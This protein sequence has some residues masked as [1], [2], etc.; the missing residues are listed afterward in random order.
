LREISDDWLICLYREGNQVAIDLLFERYSVFL[1]GFISK[2][3]KKE[4][5]CYEYEDL[6]QELIPVFI[7]CIAKYDE[8]NGCFYYF[9]KTVIERKLIDCIFKI[10]RR[11]KILSLDT[12]CYEVK[13]ESDFYC[14]CEEGERDYY[15]TEIYG[16]MKEKLSD[17]ELKIIDLKVDG[18]SYREIASILNISKQAIY[19]KVISIKNIVKDVLEK[20]D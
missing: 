16:K 2:I 19:R 3:T 1:Y 6:Y 9:A 8:D 20:I 15:S 12:F 13:D 18:Y 5:L 14:V 10:K 7:D 11:E 4:G 17:F